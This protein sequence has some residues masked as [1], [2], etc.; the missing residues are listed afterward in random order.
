MYLLLSLT[1]LPEMEKDLNSSP[2]INIQL[3]KNSVEALK[4]TSIRA[5]NLSTL[6]FIQ[7]R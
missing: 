6:Y 2:K 3:K 5:N 7:C 1:Y 4:V